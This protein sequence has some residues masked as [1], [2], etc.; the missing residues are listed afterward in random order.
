MNLDI[1]QTSTVSIAL[2]II[3]ATSLATV[4]LKYRK[5]VQGAEYLRGKSLRL[6]HLIPGV[7]YVVKHHFR[8]TMCSDADSCTLFLVLT[9][10]A[11]QTARVVVVEAMDVISNHPLVHGDIVEVDKSGEHAKLRLIQL[12]RPCA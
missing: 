8:P 4:Y 1:F 7:K 5:L 12:S 2:N 11:W 10:P 6:K 3:L 9:S